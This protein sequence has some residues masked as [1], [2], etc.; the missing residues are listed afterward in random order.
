M[1]YFPVERAPFNGKWHPECGLGSTTCL[2]KKSFINCNGYRVAD[3][4]VIE[5]LDFTLRFLRK[6]K[7]AIIGGEYLYLYTYLNENFGNNLNTKDCM[8]FLKRHITSYI[9]AWFCSHNMADPV[10]EGLKLDEIISLIN[11]LPKSDRYVIY[12]TVRYMVPTIMATKKYH[13]ES[14]KYIFQ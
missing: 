1:E 7:T 3:H 10:E 6:Y 11:K 13:I 14:Q 9:S 4:L 5:D 8:K 12:E 2:T